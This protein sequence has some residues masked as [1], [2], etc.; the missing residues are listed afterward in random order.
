MGNSTLSK[1]KAKAASIAA[2]TGTTPEN[3]QSHPK[4]KSKGKG[5]A[6]DRLCYGCGKTGHISRNWPNPA[7]GKG[8]GKAAKGSYYGGK[9]SW[10]QPSNGI[11]PLCA[12]VEKPQ[13]H[14]DLEGFVKP[15]KTVRPVVSSPSMSVN[16][17]TK[18]F[19]AKFENHKEQVLEE[20]E[21]EFQN[22]EGLEIPQQTSKRNPNFQNDRKREDKS[23]EIKSEGT[24]QRRKIHVVTT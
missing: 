12:L 2:K 17:K 18:F 9:A 7:K 1:E 10:S 11:K 21:K 4:G 23:R 24:R 15:A 13:V 6:D 22:I 16:C 20:T 19:P 3:V 14:E 5:R 8:K